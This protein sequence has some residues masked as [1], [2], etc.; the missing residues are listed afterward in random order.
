ME[1]QK[2]TTCKNCG[3]QFVG[4]FCNNCGQSA[5]THRMNF[6]FLWHDI[7]H[8]LL[9]F[10]KG[11]FYT[12]KELFT[13]PGHSIRAYVEGKRVNHFKPFS[14]II[15]LAT[16]YGFL[17]LY[18]NVNITDG[19]IDVKDEKFDVFKKI[20]EW[21]KSHYV[22]YTFF[23]LP[24]S[25]ISSFIVFRD[26]KYNLIEHFV[27]NAFITAQMLVIQLL[28][29]PITY[30][31][32]GTTLGQVTFILVSII[33]FLLIIWTYA[34]FF[35]K[36]SALRASLMAVLSYVLMMVAIMIC[37]IAVGGLYFVFYGQLH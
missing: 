16:I 11:I 23:T 19:M 17:S 24:F 13:R 28:V 22:A 1:I 12:T 31:Y 9:H 6:H 8:G 15:L 36:L 26:Q 25:A 14:M 35:N 18:F 4:K 5:T 3:H 10:D 7:Q 20:D 32:Q 27:L 33:G 30:F 29:F 2:D 21:T 34:Q 37:S